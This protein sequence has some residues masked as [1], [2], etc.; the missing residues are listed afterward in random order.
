MPLYKIVNYE[1]TERKCVVASTL[2]EL[3][4]KGKFFISFFFITEF[5]LGK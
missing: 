2:E 5:A 4:K 3:A 1:R